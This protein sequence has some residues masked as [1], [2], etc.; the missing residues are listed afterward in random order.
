MIEQ[1]RQHHLQFQTVSKNIP[2]IIICPANNCLE[3]TAHFLSHQEIYEISHYQHS[4]L[5]IIHFLN[6]V[7]SLLYLNLT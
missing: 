7:D 4:I 5:I 6:L 2:S 3:K 1:L